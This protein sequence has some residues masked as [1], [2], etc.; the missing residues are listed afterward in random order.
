MFIAEYPDSKKHDVLD[1][2][3][4]IN[5]KSHGYTLFL[6]TERNLVCGGTSMFVP[7]KFLNKKGFTTFLSRAAGHVY[8]NQPLIVSLIN[9]DVTPDKVLNYFEAKRL[10]LMA[11]V[12]ENIKNSENVKW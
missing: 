8:V 11:E 6:D 4:I 3:N 2:I 7:G 1:L 5:S 9:E 12:I 10:E